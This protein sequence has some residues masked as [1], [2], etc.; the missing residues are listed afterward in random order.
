MPAVAFVFAS[1]FQRLGASTSSEGFLDQVRQ[2]SFIFMILGA[3]SFVFMTGNSTFLETAADEMTLS[4]K[5][6][7]FQ[8]LLRQDMTYFDIKDI[9]ATATIISTNGQKVQTWTGTQIWWMHSIDRHFCWWNFLCLL[10][11]VASFLVITRYHSLYH[12][13]CLVSHYHE[14]ISV[15]K[16]QCWLC[17][18]GLDC[19]ND[20]ILHE[21]YSFPQCRP[22]RY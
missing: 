22:S 1:S 18:S 8:A 15:H 7:W 6:R 5:T 14:S 3:L 21:N 13:E 12:G 10:G 2:L 4:L 11:L 16:S 20:C 19:P 9:S 17:S